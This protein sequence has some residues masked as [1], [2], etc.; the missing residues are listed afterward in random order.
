M[1]CG[2]CL[3]LSNLPPR[4][5]VRPSVCISIGNVCGHRVTYCGQQTRKPSQE[6]VGPFKNTNYVLWFNSR[7]TLVNTTLFKF[8]NISSVM[9]TSDLVNG[10]FKFLFSLSSLFHFDSLNL[11]YDLPHQSQMFPQGH[12]V[13]LKFYPLPEV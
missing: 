3:G 5:S 7:G 13:S 6:Q 10:L 8:V 4:L 2:S 12:K 1:Q 11:A 9:I